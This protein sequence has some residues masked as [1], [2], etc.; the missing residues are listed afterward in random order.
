M[1]TG[2]KQMYFGDRANNNSVMTSK[3]YTLYNDKSRT[4]GQGD[5]VDRRA[6]VYYSNIDANQ[7]KTLASQFINLKDKVPAGWNGAMAFD[8]DGTGYLQLSNFCSGEKC[9]IKEKDLHVARMDFFRFYEKPM[10]TR[11]IVMIMLP[12]LLNRTIVRITW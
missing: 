2:E 4:V 11:F 7:T 8:P 6:M 3:L 9:V 12:S 10:L 5:V 1:G